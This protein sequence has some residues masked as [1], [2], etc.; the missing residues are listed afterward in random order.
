MMRNL[1][2]VALLGTLVG[3]AQTAAQDAAPL[4]QGPGLSA[5]HPGD[6]GMDKD[7]AVIFAENFEESTLD[8]VVKRWSE[9]SNKDGKVQSL[10]N[11]VSTA[12]SGRQSLLM[13]ATMGENSG[14]HLFTTWKPGVDRAF[15]RFY[16]KFAP[17]HAYEHH[18]VE[19]GGYNPPTPWPS[20]QAG[21]KPNGNDRI[22]IF[23]DA[24]GWYGKFPPPGVW[25]LYSY[26]HEMKVSADGKYWGN[27]LQPAKPVQ[28]PRGQWQCVEVMVKLNSAPDKADGEL[29]MWVDGTPVLHVVKGIQHGPWSG[30]GF[31]VVDSGGETFPGLN[32]RTSMDLTINH[33]WL[34]H[35]IDEGTQQPNKLA[36]PTRVNRV[37]F[38][39]VVV[40]K[41]YIGPIQPG[42]SAPAP[43]ASAAKP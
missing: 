9:A 29:A 6:V 33:L 16:T 38:D 21:S 3:A 35:Y 13:T 32:L 15:L 19:L 25:N 28:V 1:V 36:N 26:W 24:V 42:A 8:E 27:C 4:P 22:S 5:K 14:G 2:A 11:D 7:P 41:E 30:M 37:W 43:A 18:F 10:S 40:A 39:D 17:D 12:S 31:Q 34:E 20:P 23:V